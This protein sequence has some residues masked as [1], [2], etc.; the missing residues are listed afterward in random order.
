M[1]IKVKLHDNTSLVESTP[2]SGT[3]SD[4]RL[5]ILLK[6]EIANRIAADAFLQEE[7]DEIIENGAWYLLIEEQTNGSI[8]ISLLNKEEQVLCT[9]TIHLTE[10]IIKESVLDYENAKIIYTCNDDSTI[11]VDVSDIVSA[12][13]QLE[14][15]LADEV[16]RAT[17]EEARIEQKLDNE[18]SRATQADEA[19][20]NKIDLE[21]QNR[22]DD[23][24]A[25]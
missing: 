6:E 5:E 11:E 10:K 4:K 9:R 18:I 23:V 3:L 22:I 21:I 25:E 7:I 24:D 12:I 20:D 16:S 17:G 19:L 14:S 15:D 13:H 1:P 2:T 8:D